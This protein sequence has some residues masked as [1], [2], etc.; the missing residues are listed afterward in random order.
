[1]QF[2]SRAI[3]VLASTGIVVVLTGVPL[4][5]TSAGPADAAKVHGGPDVASYQHPNGHAI[6][7]TKVA[8]SGQS[9]AIV[10][11]TEGTT[12]VNPY[13]AS[14]YAAAGKAG[15]VRG[16]YH[17]ARPSKPVVATA[18]AQAKAFAATVGSVN[19][20]K[21]LPPALD[22]EVTGGLSPSQLVTWAQTFLLEMRTLTGR[23]PMLYTYPNFWIND[24]NDPQAF[25]RFPLWMAA[26]SST[27][28]TATIWQYTD[29]AHITGIKGGVDRSKYV[30]SIGP[31]WSVI[32]NGTV[33]T[34][35]TAAAP[36]APFGLTVTPSD[37]QVSV[38]WRPGDSGTSRVTQYTIT[39]SSGHHTVTVPGSSTSGTVTG[40]NPDTQY[41]FTV[42]AVNKVG[43]S[44]TSAPSVPVVP[45]VTTHWS[46]DHASSVVDGKGLAFS[47]TLSRTTT[48]SGVAGRAATLY[49]RHTGTTTWT[50]IRTMTTNSH[51]TVSTT[52]H[53]HMSADLKIVWAG[54]T[55]VLPA[56]KTTLVVVRPAV[57]AHLSKTKVKAGHAVTLS[58]T[59]AK[60]LA[61]ETVTREGYYSGGWHV[62]A[63]ST[64][65]ATGHYSFT[66]TP[67]D[68]T[69][70]RYRVMSAALNGRGAG[71]SPTVQLTVT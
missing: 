13:F 42:Q 58:G 65:S 46:V 45:V 62:W 68:A 3:R 14:D 69:V 2:A 1:M 12:Y 57:S 37:G 63:T 41:T 39:A 31:A 19:Q 6:N 59:V 38:A 40:L 44:P 30:G 64:V 26:Y 24:V 70:D 10:K 9:F 28:P 22:L 55:A 49:H 4:V 15:L 29:D 53:P 47:A 11:A 50:P 35:W 67:T 60:F 17:F 5:L 54:T 27:Q 23:T 21:T 18:T 25:A 48:G 36:A 16:S 52:L 32:D 20:T 33:A 7:W 56:S 66:I 71:I 51:G 34:P 61:G 8:K 43:A